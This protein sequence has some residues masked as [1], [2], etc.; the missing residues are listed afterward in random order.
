[1]LINVHMYKPFAAVIIP[2]YPAN[3]PRDTCFPHIWS[4]GQAAKANRKLTLTTN[5]G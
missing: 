3:I 5:G 2:G 1:M 4:R